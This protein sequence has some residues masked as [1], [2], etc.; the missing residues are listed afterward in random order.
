[1]FVAKGPPEA[2]RKAL[3]AGRF[4]AGTM[5]ASGMAA[6]KLK[7]PP[8]KVSLPVE[9]SEARKLPPNLKV[10]APRTCETLS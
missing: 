7:R 2:S 5:L 1:V 10:C 6:P 9:T 3:R 8:K 4:A